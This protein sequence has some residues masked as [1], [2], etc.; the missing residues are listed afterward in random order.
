MWQLGSEQIVSHQD[1]PQTS[2]PVVDPTR[3]EPGCLA[4]RAYES[5]RGLPVFAISSK[6]ASPLGMVHAKLE[7]QALRND[8]EQ[9]TV[10][11]GS[12]VG[13]SAV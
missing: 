3:A 1:I 12:A 2:F 4:I 13:C 11:S 8:F 10:V 5:L 7:R 6:V 9:H